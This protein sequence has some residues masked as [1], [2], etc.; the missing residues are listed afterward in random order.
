MPELTEGLWL[1]SGPEPLVR[2][3]GARQVGFL[4]WDK[5]RYKCANTRTPPST[6]LP[7]TATTSSPMR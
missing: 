2:A 4:G 5:A 7:G 1:G 3:P 6:C